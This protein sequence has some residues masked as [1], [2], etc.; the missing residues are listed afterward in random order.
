MTNHISQRITSL[1]KLVNT[2]FHLENLDKIAVEC[3]NLA[4][5]SSYVLPFF[6]L[7]H[8]VTEMSS[9]MDGEAVNVDQFREITANLE[10]AFNSVLDKI[11]KQERVSFEDLELIVRVQIQNVSV[12]RSER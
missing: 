11:E 3:A 1:R 10:K 8:L 2:G 5:D 4:Q 9:V 6:T 7:K 12:Y